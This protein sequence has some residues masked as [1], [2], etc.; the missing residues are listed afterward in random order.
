VNWLIKGS[1]SVKVGLDDIPDRTVTT[2]SFPFSI[3]Q[4]VN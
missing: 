4:V 3:I 2:V 1:H